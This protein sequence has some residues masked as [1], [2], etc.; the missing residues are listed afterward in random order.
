MTIFRQDTTDY[1]TGQESNASLAN[2]FSLLF[3]TPRLPEVPC[4]YDVYMVD[5]T[6]GIV[7]GYTID[8]NYTLVDFMLQCKLSS[9]EVGIL[10]MSHVI[11]TREDLQY[12][13]SSGSQSF[14]LFEVSHEIIGSLSETELSNDSIS[15]IK[16]VM[17]ELF[18][19]LEIRIIGDSRGVSLLIPYLDSSTIS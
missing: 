17:C 15:D 2:L 1:S 19:D 9:S 11:Q 10:V 6:N 12:V 4:T 5:I 7:T 14:V 13:K 3:N 8:D 18:T 16:N